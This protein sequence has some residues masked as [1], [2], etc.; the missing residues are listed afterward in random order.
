MAVLPA[1]AADKILSFEKDAQGL[2]ITTEK[3]RLELSWYADDVVRVRFVPGGVFAPD[4][5]VLDRTMLVE[6]AQQAVTWEL[7]ETPKE[8]ILKSTELSVLVNRETAAVAF[9]DAAGKE[10]LSERADGNRAFE[11]FMS[12]EVETTKG[13]LVFNMD[14]TDPLY[15]M[16]QH[17]DGFMNRRHVPTRLVQHNTRISMPV[18]VSPAGFGLFFNHMTQMDINEGSS[19]PLKD[20]KI[21]NVDAAVLES[22]EE[23]MASHKAAERF[24]TTDYKPAVTGS[25]RFTTAVSGVH[26]FYIQHADPFKKKQRPL[27]IWIDGEEILHY[28]NFWNESAMGASVELK[29]GKTYTLEFDGAVKDSMFKV[30]VPDNRFD[31]AIESAEDLDYFFLGG[32]TIDQQIQGYRQ[33]TGAAPVPPKYMFGLWQCRER[34]KTQED[35]LQNAREFRARKIPVD[36]IVQD[37][38]WWSADHSRV[39]HPEKYP[40]PKAMID[41]LKSLNLHSMFSVWAEV[42]NKGDEKRWGHEILNGDNLNVYDAEVREIFWSEVRENLFDIGADAYWFDSTEGFP[43]HMRE[44]TE[45]G[46]GYMHHNDFS[47][48]VSKASYEGHR[49]AGEDLKRP[50]ILT[51][52]AWGGQQRYGSVMWSGDISSTWDHFRKQIAAG[53]NFCMAGVPY[54][55]TDTAGFFR[56]PGFVPQVDGGADEDQYSSAYFNEL[57][58]RWMQ[59]SAFCP[60]QRTHGYRSKTEMW[61]Y[62]PETYAAMLDMVN[63]RYRILPYSYSLGA[64]ISNDGYTGMRGLAMDFGRDPNVASIYDQ[65][66]YGPAFM[67]CPVIEEGARRR[68]VYLPAGTKWIDFWTGG[69]YDGGQTLDVEA[70][71]DRLPVFVKAGSIVPCGPDVEYAGQKPWDALEIRIYPG[72]DG[73]FTLY[74]DEGENHNYE[75]G[76]FSEITFSWNDAEQE[77]TVSDCQGEFPGMLKSREFNITLVRPVKAVGIPLESVCDKTVKYTGIA[78]TV[79]YRSIR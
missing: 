12:G 56:T 58:T 5:A 39:F 1:S 65:F 41:E 21:T 11:P 50:V 31:V 19:A 36:I 22:T 3:G 63:L 68:S 66:M 38:Q 33:L 48:F 45:F 13:R 10:L 27:R 16:G 76:A 69:A 15:G 46:P 77:L 18:V 71:L 28:I 74:E 49:Q 42:K 52:S 6:S 47:L 60:V 53:L 4:K 75:N 32:A 79:S 25:A 24:K 55:T 57:L 44:M 20:L 35:L 37:W 26:G 62:K 43:V 40:E 78:I 70:P 72:A 30:A 23:D 51:R 34:Y 59:Y 54:W 61:R 64:M 8:L 9:L 67:A 7:L 14:D 2:E 29:A 17:Q 73:S